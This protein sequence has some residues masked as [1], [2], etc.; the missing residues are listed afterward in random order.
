MKNAEKRKP[1]YEMIQEN[2]KNGQLPEGFSLE[3]EGGS[4]SIRW[5]PGARDGVMLNHTA[6]FEPDE[7]TNGKILEILKLISDEN[8][9]RHLERIFGMLEELDKEHS[10][11]KM[12]DAIRAAVAANQKTLNLM[13]IAKFGD[14]MICRGVSF[15]AVKFGLNLLSGFSMPFVEEVHITF[16]AYDEFTYYAARCL[17]SG[18]WKDGNEQLFRLARNLRGWGRI[19]AVEYLRP[20][21]EEI[22]DWLLF[23]GADNTVVRQYSSDICL[24]KSGAAERLEA[25]A[26]AEEFETIGGLIGECLE[27]GPCPG[28]SD[29][30]RLLAGYL[31]AAKDRTY[32]RELIRT[33]RD[34]AEENELNRKIIGAAEKLLG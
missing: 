33:I 12:Y 27:S 1:I 11:V 23:E 29:A 22:R 13:N 24:W 2:L 32:D 3:D 6:P 19:H 7:E 31:N 10:I 17:S 5:A 20:E 14:G 26:S 8:N 30:E 9:A 34:W 18:M 4:D 25:G 21:T 16:G 28:L 15:L